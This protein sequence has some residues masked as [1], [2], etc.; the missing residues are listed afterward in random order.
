MSVPRS[1]ATAGLAALC[2]AALGQPSAAQQP[3][4]FERYRSD[5]ERVF[6]TPRGG[7]GPSMSPCV[8]CHVQ[9]GTPLKLQPLET[10]DDGSV[11]WTEEQSR[12]NFEVVSRLVTPGHPERSRLLLK[13][14]AVEA[15][16][17]PFHV[18]GKFFDS[19]ADPEW[20]RMAAWVRESEPSAGMGDRETDAPPVDFQFF[21]S[22]VQQ[23]FV[24]KREGRAECV[25]CHN[26]GS[27][28][29][30]TGLDDQEGWSVEQAR[31]NFEVLRRYIEPGYPLMSRFLTHPLAPE[32]GGDPYHGGGRRWPSQND[33]EWQMLA[34]WVRGETPACR[35]G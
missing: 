22:C 3:L 10:R 9:S 28:G 18:G 24:S 20:R 33:S 32:A 13:A 19:Q 27:R 15:G 29:F 26:G 34:A 11:Y 16:G 8:T 2:L 31:A 30:A 6:L 23:I 5:V 14:L 17:D 7:H 21:Q 1:F 35:V 12:R 25:H 4:S